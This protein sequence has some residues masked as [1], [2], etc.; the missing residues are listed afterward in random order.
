[1][2]QV[3][4]IINFQRVTDQRCCLFNS[5]FVSEPSKEEKKLSRRI[6][7]FFLCALSASEG[8][9]RGEVDHMMMSKCIRS[10]CLQDIFQFS[11]VENKSTVHGVP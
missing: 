10:N 11:L 9:G 4:E 2:R 6:F 1:M 8:S 5:I 7:H 3:A